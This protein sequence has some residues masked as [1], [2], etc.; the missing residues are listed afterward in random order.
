[1]NRVEKAREKVIL[2]NRG[3]TPYGG[4]QKRRKNQGLPARAREVVKDIAAASRRMHRSSY[5]SLLSSARAYSTSR[6]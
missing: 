6:K 3:T 5:L 4:E 1:M 2:G